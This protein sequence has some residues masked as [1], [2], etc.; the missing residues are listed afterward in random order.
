MAHRKNSILP[1][2]IF[3]PRC[4]SS[5]DFIFTL[6]IGVHISQLG[7]TIAISHNIPVN[8]KHCV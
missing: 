2:G 7:V 5:I 3:M 8:N 4:N 1:T 6:S